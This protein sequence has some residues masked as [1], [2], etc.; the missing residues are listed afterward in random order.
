V[1]LT[2]SKLTNRQ[3]WFEIIKSY[4]IEV[5]EV[6]LKDLIRGILN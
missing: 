3:I 1:S 6:T 4:L 2:R 5:T